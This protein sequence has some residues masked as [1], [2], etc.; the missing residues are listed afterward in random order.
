MPV[1]TICL[2][3]SRHLHRF[4]VRR[5][6]S[7]VTN[8]T[9]ALLHGLPPTKDFDDVAQYPDLPKFVTEKER[10]EHELCQTVA[11]L[12]TVEERQFYVNKPKYFGWYTCKINLENIPYGTLALA[13]RMTL[14]S[15]E[16]GLPEARYGAGVKDSKATEMADKLAPLV[17]SMVVEANRRES[18]SSEVHADKV[19]G[20]EKTWSLPP[21]VAKFRHMKDKT[22]HFVKTLNR[23]LV[24]HLISDED[25]RHLLAA[26]ID[27]NS[28]NEGFWFKGGFYPDR[29]AVMKRK[30]QKKHTDNFLKNPLKSIRYHPTLNKRLTDEDV[31]QKHDKAIQVMGNNIM[32]LR[33]PHMV[34]PFAGVEDPV[35]RKGK[36]IPE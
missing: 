32:Q 21:E 36:D 9:R 4:R 29:K 15:V 7:P 18:H 10:N 19:F 11:A 6:L 26:Q 30:S 14:T 5:I 25:C 35:A 24:K 2:V 17:R 28:R 3:G 16:R 12:K 1:P 13:Q 23:L 31:W 8:V 33:F 27:F 20:I 34:A 22:S